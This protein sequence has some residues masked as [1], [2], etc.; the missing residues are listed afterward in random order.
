MKKLF[1]LFVISFLFFFTTN[2]NE[3]S[4]LSAH[5]IIEP[6]TTLTNGML[7]EF[8]FVTNG[9]GSE[10]K[11]SELNWKIKNI[12]SVGAKVSFTWDFL[13]FSSEFSSSFPKS[14]GIMV[15]SDWQKQTD[16]IYDQN[17]KTNISYNENNLSFYNYLNLKIKYSPM[18]YQKYSIS[19]LLGFMYNSIGFIGKNGYGYYGDKLNSKTGKDVSYDDPDALFLPT[20]TLCPISYSRNTINSYL[21][22]TFLSNF[23]DFFQLYSEFCLSVFNS[24]ISDDI[25]FSNMSATKGRIYE[26]RMKGFFSNYSFIAAARFFVTN[27]ISLQ[28]K[29]EINQQLLIRGVT[30]VGSNLITKSVGLTRS[31]YAGCSGNYN[32]LTLSVD[33]RY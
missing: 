26:D 27:N 20:G 28:T 4:S 17:L 6:L 1:L 12:Y 18:Y 31:S 14:S 19:P 25:H 10:H 23:N 7:N 21:G 22:F 30:Y 9:D 13:E 33:F 11:L 8:V 15:D 32:K 29:F 5:I 24:V 3:Q 16:R 2:A